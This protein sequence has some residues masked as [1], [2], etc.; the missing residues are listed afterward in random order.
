MI[1]AVRESRAETAQEALETV[2]TDLRNMNS[3]VSVT[4]EIHD[5]VVDIKPLFL[6]CDYAD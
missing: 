6:V 2:K 4:Q 5:D 1:R 3:S